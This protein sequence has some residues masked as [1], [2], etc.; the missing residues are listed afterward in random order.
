MCLP[1][2]MRHYLRL[3]NTVFLFLP[4]F[5]YQWVAD[6]PISRIFDWAVKEGSALSLHRDVWRHVSEDRNLLGIPEIFECI[7]T[8][9]IG[10]TDIVVG[11]LHYQKWL[12]PVWGT[13][14]MAPLKFS[15]YLFIKLFLGIWPLLFS[16]AFRHLSWHLPEF[17]K[18]FYD[19]LSIKS[20]W[21]QFMII[22]KSF[23]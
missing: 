21:R 13:K 2:N 17:S 16:Y 15:N 18:G 3:F 5:A 14:H 1:V 20:C 7:W 9:L 4:V 23:F 8:F 6:R 19:K 12:Q 22:N 11:S 10:K